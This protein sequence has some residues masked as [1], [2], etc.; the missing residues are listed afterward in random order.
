M[1]LPWVRYEI[2]YRVDPDTLAE[3][4]ARTR[5]I[6]V[7]DPYS[8]NGVGYDNYS[9]YFDSPELRYSRGKE[10]GLEIRTKPRLRIYKRPEDHEPLAHF[11]ELK[12]R[13]GMAATKERVVIPASMAPSLLD[14]IYLGSDAVSSFSPVLARLAYLVRRHDLRPVVCVL[15]RREAHSCP[16]APGLRITFDRLLSASSRT[17]VDT[18]PRLFQ[19]VLP[20][21]ETII[22]VKYNARMPNWLAHVVQRLEIDRVSVSKYVTAMQSLAFGRSSDVPRQ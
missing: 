20:F 18:P 13:R 6:L 5:A 3:F 10:E 16:L 9:T 21:N 12:H 7:A 8:V 17:A 2:K 11:F 22:E 4:R 1:S 15:Y 14:P 19:P